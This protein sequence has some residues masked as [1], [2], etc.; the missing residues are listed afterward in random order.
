MNSNVYC[1][2]STEVIRQNSRVMVQLSVFNSRQGSDLHAFI[3]AFLFYFLF[4]IFLFLRG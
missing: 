1:A 3:L 2:Y 4:F